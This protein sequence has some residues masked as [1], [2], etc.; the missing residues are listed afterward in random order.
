[1]KTVFKYNLIESPHQQVQ[2]PAKS[3]ILHIGLQDKSVCI[4]CQVDTEQPQ[5]QR[6]ISMVLTGVEGSFMSRGKYIG[7]L[8]VDGYA[9]H[10]FDGGEVGYAV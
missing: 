10:Y 4:W 7:T 5:V 3:Q 8:A 6:V 2:M 9:M 1:M